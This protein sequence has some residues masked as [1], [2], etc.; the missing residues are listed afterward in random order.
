MNDDIM[1][2]RQVLEKE[3]NSVLP[4]K[5]DDPVTDSNKSVYVNEF[6]KVSDFLS[7]IK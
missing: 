6:T 1:G 4:T 5:R 7:R 2:V 3:F